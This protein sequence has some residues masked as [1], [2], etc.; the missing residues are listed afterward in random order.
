MDEVRSLR[1]R[2]RSASLGAKLVLFSAILTAFS[3][4]PAFLALDIEIRKNTRDLLATT[5]AHHQR[6]LLNLQKRDLEQLVRT[7]TLMT[8]SPTLRAAME[9]YRSEAAPGVRARSDLRGMN[10]AT[11]VLSL[12]A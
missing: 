1:S 9:I 4:L 2:W 3:V 10:L 6:M 5:L 8:D 12:H 11:C 7:S